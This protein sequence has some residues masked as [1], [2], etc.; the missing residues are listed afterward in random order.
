[1]PLPYYI[2]IYSHVKEVFEIIFLVL[3][4][5]YNYITFSFIRSFV[6]YIKYFIILLFIQIVACTTLSHYITLKN[7]VEKER[8]R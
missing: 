5:M 4:Y 3:N 7:K 2:S 1:M 8:E 6:R